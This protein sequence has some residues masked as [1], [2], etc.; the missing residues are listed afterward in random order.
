MTC[1]TTLLEFTMKVGACFLTDLRLVGRMLYS[2]RT[3]LR[4]IKSLLKD[5]SL[6]TRTLMLSK[7][8]SFEMVSLSRNGR[9]KLLDSLEDDYWYKFSKEN[10]KYFRVTD[11]KTMMNNLLG[12]RIKTMMFLADIVTF[13]KDK[14]T[15]YYLVY[16]LSG[17]LPPPPDEGENGYYK[18]DLSE[19]QCRELLKKGIYYDIKEFR[20]YMETYGRQEKD[21]TYLS[22]ARGIF[23]SN[24]N[25]FVVYAGRHGDNKMISIRPVGETRLLE[26]LAPVLKVTNVQRPLPRLDKKR[27]NERTGEE[28]ITEKTM[29]EPYALIIS[30]GNSLVYSTANGN[31]NG[32]IK[33]LDLNELSRQRSKRA[34]EDNA[35]ERVAWLKGESDLYRRIFI[36]PCT[37]NG[38]SSLEYITHATVEEYFEATDSLMGN[39]ERFEKNKGNVLYPYTIIIDNERYPAIY[40]PAYEAKEL[41]R[42]F[43]MKHTVAIIT[44]RDMTDAISHSVRKPAIYID[45]ED[46]TIIPTDEV[47]I[48]NSHG[49]PQGQ[50][51]IEN[52]LAKQNKKT[53]KKEI[54]KIADQLGYENITTFYNDVATK[55]LSAYEVACMITNTEPLPPDEEK[56][57]RHKRI[58]LTMGEAFTK[59]VY[60]AA[61]YRNMSASNYVKQ[62]IHDKVI[63]DANEYRKLKRENAKTWRNK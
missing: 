23:L 9:I 43:T 30:D 27:I 17:L 15:L 39:D 11:V 63:E 58:T 51:M 14:P 5:E 54:N 25:C 42:I 52:E 57:F 34:K 41:Y 33:K 55:K 53:A 61:R 19:S 20:E 47:M 16:K 60:N 37:E 7:D 31:P 28:I 38:I 26:A 29:G 45:T 35:L 36:T 21:T 24:T 2:E 49:Y 8:A 59:E 13:P 44:Y 50:K 3:S 18:N 40:M 32:R 62:L 22:K 56:T 1:A 6:E 46:M 4:A 10:E 48:Y 12:S